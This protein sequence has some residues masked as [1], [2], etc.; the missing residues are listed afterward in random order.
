MDRRIQQFIGENFREGYMNG[1]TRSIQHE[2]V[3]KLDHIC[4]HDVGIL[5]SQSHRVS[6]GRPT[7]SR[8]FGRD[9][10]LGYKL[11]LTKIPF[12]SKRHGRNANR[13]LHLFVGAIASA[14]L[15]CSFEVKEVKM[16][17]LSNCWSGRMALVLADKHW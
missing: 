16:V 15:R 17:V 6:R 12:G 14:A 3:R 8:E 7:Y 10:L 1:W 11:Q 5:S 9:D 2:D 4:S 13:I